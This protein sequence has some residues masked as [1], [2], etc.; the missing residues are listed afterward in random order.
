MK[1]LKII[2]AGTPEFAARHLAALLN[3]PHD[4]VA[5]Y[6]QADRPAGR[7]RKLTASPV[8]TLALLHQLRIEQPLSLK[9]PDVQKQ[10]AS[11]QADLMIVVAYGLILPK[12]ILTL[13]RLGC[14]NVHASLLPRWRGAAPIQ[15]AILHGDH[16]TGICLMQMD[17]GLDTGDVL[18]QTTCEITST[19][20]A[21]SLHDKL[22]ELGAN[23][24]T[25]QLAVISHQSVTPQPQDND[26]ATYAPK[27]TK[28]DARIDWQQTASH[29]ERC[30]RAYNPWPVAFTTLNEQS[31]RIWE[32]ELTTQVSATDPGTITAVHTDCLDVATGDGVLRITRLQIP[33]HKNLTVKEILNAYRESFLVNS[34][35]I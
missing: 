27:V 32:A 11:L 18:V 24:L 5:V 14:I 29:I 10:L 2:F 35:F 33:G 7:G 31:I 16:Q 9:E 17:E 26:Q 1:T 4:I 6:T 12:D 28:A 23:S 20:T 34:Q 22:A 21:A 30:I 8:K 15:A 19:E 13:P 25:K 3:T